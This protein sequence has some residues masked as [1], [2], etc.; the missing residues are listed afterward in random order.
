MT[1]AIGKATAASSGISKRFIQSFD[2]VILGL[3]GNH[4]ILVKTIGPR[5][6]QTPIIIA[7]SATN[8]AS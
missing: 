4:I 5:I 3:L 8:S 2:L 6:E 7:I 1:L